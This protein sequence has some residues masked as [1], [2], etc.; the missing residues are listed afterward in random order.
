MS[1]VIE[2][3]RKYAIRKNKIIIKFNGINLMENRYRKI[4]KF[5]KIKLELNMTKSEY[6]NILRKINNESILPY[7]F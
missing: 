4:V 5:T 6:C 7:I 2:R 1:N 3:F